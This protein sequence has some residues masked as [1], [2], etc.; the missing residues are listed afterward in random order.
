MEARF[1]TDIGVSRTRNEDAGGVFVNLTGQKMLL[2][3]DGMGGHN[4]GDVASQFVKEQ[5]QTRFESENLIE[6]SQAEEWL[7][8]QISEINHELYLLS[9][10]NDE[11]QGMGTTLVAV[12][13]FDEKIMIANIGDSRAY[14]VNER[15]LR[16]VTNDH[17]FVNH[18][19]MAGELSKEEAAVHPQRNIITKVIGTDKRVYPDIFV[20]ET[21]LYDN[22][23]LSSDG[24]TDYVQEHVIH[25]LLN[26]SKSIDEIGTEMIDAALQS[27]VRDNVSFVIGRFGGVQ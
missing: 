9:H 3:C 6:W 20:Y 27:E 2:I 25:Q 5:M 14:L 26:Q 19:V 10:Q 7:K 21:K 4:A 16:Q 13:I 12:L 8:R 11:L 1:F 18:L 22:I 15:E 17:T 24:L 23:L